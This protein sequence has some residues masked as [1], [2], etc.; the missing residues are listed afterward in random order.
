MLT[1]KLLDGASL[2]ED[3]QKLA[4]TLGSC[5]EYETM[6]S[7]LTHIFTKSTST[8]EVPHDFDNIKQDEALYSKNSIQWKQSK[9]PKVTK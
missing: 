7:A 3:N 4:V 5:L 1:F 2:T 8:A 6:K 9:T